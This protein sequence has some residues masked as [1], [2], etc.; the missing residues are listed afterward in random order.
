[1]AKTKIEISRTGDGR[2]AIDVKEYGADWSFGRTI[3]S[4]TLEPKASKEF[5]RLIRETQGIRSST[6]AL[7]LNRIGL[8]L[9]NEVYPDHAP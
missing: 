2:V 7:W 5:I 3:D 8:F 1:M 6:A 9:D 4:M